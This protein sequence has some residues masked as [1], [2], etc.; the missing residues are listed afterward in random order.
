LGNEPAADHLERTFA[1]FYDYRRL[2]IDY[3]RSVSNS[4]AMIRLAAINL[5]LRRLWDTS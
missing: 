4:R 2:T 5:M 3:E 1:W